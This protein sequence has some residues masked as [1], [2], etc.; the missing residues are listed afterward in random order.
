MARP[1]VART[2]RECRILV[3]LATAHPVEIGGG[4]RSNAYGTEGGV[5]GGGRD[6]VCVC[7]CVLEGGER[8]GGRT[9]RRRRGQSGQKWPKPTFWRW[10][11]SHGVEGEAKGGE[12]LRGGVAK[13]AHAHDGVCRG[14]R[15]MAEGAHAL[16]GVCQGERERRRKRLTPLMASVR[17][18]ERR[19][20][21]L[22]PMTELQGG[23]KDGGRAPMMASTREGGR[24]GHACFCVRT[25]THVR[26][27]VRSRVTVSV[28]VCGASHRCM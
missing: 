5:E 4:R 23:E 13:E 18:R 11:N 14:E 17:E 22:T 26:A 15:E 6:C 2:P 9:W 7:V 12:V 28:T 10:S 19:R 16:D 1:R 24:K 27:C 21:G 25:R 8:G 20:K 3:R